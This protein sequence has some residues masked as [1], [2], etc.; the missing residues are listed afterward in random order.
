MRDTRWVREQGRP[1]MEW[2][3]LPLKRYADFSGRSRRKEFWFWVLAVI[4]VSVVLMLIDSALGL[5]GRSALDSSNGP[6]SIYYSAGLHGGV[7]TGLFSLAIL[8][9]NIAVAV[10]RLHD[11]NRTGWWILLPALPYLLGFI[12]ALAGAFSMNPLLA[13]IGGGLVFIGFICAIVVIV[14]YCLPG[15]KGPNTYGE[16][17]LGNTP[18]DLARTFE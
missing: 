6:G 3:L 7:L 16:D 4:I 12:L 14:W 1:S 15:T 8:I 18:E 5:G 9:P 11:T 2:M 10:R 13:V 17:P